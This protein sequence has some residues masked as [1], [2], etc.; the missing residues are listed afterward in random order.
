MNPHI[1]ADGEDRLKQ[2]PEFK[3]MLRALRESIRARHSAELSAA[4][5]VRR[6]LVGWR[7]AKEYRR[8]RRRI[9]PSPGSL[10]SSNIVVNEAHAHQASVGGRT[11]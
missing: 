1:V 11:R 5:F 2:S 10:Y 8:E 3:A 4:G 6:C 9:V 7:M